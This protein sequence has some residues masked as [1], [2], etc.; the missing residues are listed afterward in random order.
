MGCIVGKVECFFYDDRAR[1]WTAGFYARG[2]TRLRN[3]LKTKREI[4]D[5]AV[6]DILGAALSQTMRDYY[7]SVFA[8]HAFYR[9]ALKNLEEYAAFLPPV[10]PVSSVNWGLNKPVRLTHRTLV[11]W[12]Y[13]TY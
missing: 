2:G 13:Y 10:L 4:L 3:T 8:R 12:V 6:G 9:D 11:S 7:D 5:P 1:L